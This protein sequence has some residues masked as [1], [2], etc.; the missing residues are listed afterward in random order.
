MNILWTK[1]KMSAAV[2]PNGKKYEL[3]KTAFPAGFVHAMEPGYKLM[4]CMDGWY[5]IEKPNG[6]K[7]HIRISPNIFS[8][9]QVIEVNQ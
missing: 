4:E 9:L 3:T 1:A 2:K 5:A 7:Y 6:A 8:T